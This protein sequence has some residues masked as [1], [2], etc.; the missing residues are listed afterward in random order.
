ME[1]MIPI[2]EFQNG[3]ELTNLKVG[4]KVDVYL[5]RIEN[6]KGQ[7]IISRDKAKKMKAWKKMEK[8]L[9]LKK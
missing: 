6:F 9:K 4:S 1:G 3:D 7:I 5:E 8:L 2:E